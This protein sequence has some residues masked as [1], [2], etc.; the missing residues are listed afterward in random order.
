[1]HTS[2]QPSSGFGDLAHAQTSTADG[3]VLRCSTPQQK[4]GVGL[5]Q[6][7]EQHARASPQRT[8]LCQ[9]APGAD[10][11]LLYGQAHAAVARLALGLARFGLGPDRPL[12]ILSGNSIDHALLVLAAMS[13]GAPVA[14]LS[15]AF[16]QFDDLSHLHSAFEV[17]TPGLVFADDALAFS[18]ALGLAQSKGLATATADEAVDPES[19]ARLSTLMASTGDA[20]RARPSGPPDDSAV[21]RLLFT[22]GSTGKPK[23]VIV[24]HGMMASN[25]DAMAQV[26]PFLAQ[27]PPV[28]VDWL[29][30]NHVFGGCLNF[31]MV[32]RHGGTLVI[33]DG[34]PMPG[35]MQRSLDNLRAFQPT[36]Y[37]GVPRA[38]T[39]LSR[40]CET[41]PAL[42]RAFFGRL[43]A[44]FS[45]GA[46]LPAAT[47]QALHSVCERATGR[48]LPL[49]IGWGA[50]ETAPVVSITTPHNRRADSIGLPVPGAEIKL[51]ANGE[52]FELRVR[53]P[54]V[55]PGYWRRPDL[56]AA[57]FD[58]QGFYAI[59]DA[60]RIDEHWQ[61]DGI[62]FDGRVAENFKLQSGTWV[63]AGAV[64][65][66]ALAA[67]GGLFDEVAVTGQDRDE[68]GL[69]VFPSLAACRALTGQPH[70]DMPAL[71]AHPAVRDATAA[72]LARLG[73]AGG[74][75]TRVT[76]ALLLDS[77]PA[78]ET[79]E[80]TDKG[81]LNQRATLG[82]RADA[83]ARLHAD[84]C[85]ADVVL[86]SRAAQ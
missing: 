48:S 14:P 59:G 43:Q 81:Y 72:A 52:K 63:Q 17:L 20:D 13:I 61:R 86:A 83:V 74:S 47:W 37:L 9:P 53:G 2:M 62:V 7:L 69:L 1:M 71:T 38:L 3:L 34:R 70:A 79:G 57:A 5:W 36:V 55:T 65:L 78:M 16:S 73:L 60:G 31:N 22:S 76:R 25:Q 77:P 23:A 46:A 4:S 33:D 39:E 29:P 49:F 64:R 80:M 82:A 30:W 66:A 6:A 32:L 40:A 10:R 45:A 68:V 67:S 54:M 58:S 42:A 75:S 85:H 15:L 26:W 44:M 51:T 18:R 56:T 41:D 84:P 50:T 35:R 21:A 12:V 24:T 11:V 27:T 28:V 19:G 8:Y